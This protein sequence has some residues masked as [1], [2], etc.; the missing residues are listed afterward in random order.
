[1]RHV[2]RSRFC[3]N[4][5]LSV[6]L[7]LRI[8][9]AEE[10][11]VVPVSQVLLEEEYQIA[12]VEGLEPLVP[13]D[14]LEPVTSITGEVKPQ[15]AYVALVL[16]PWHRGWGCLPLLCPTPDDVVIVRGECLAEV[17]FMLVWRVDPLRV[18]EQP[19]LIVRLWRRL[20]VSFGFVCSAPNESR[21]HI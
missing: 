10:V 9:Q 11:A 8:D 5:A 12:G 7:L 2:W 17:V 18:L 16:R 4:V 20:H 15:H 1:M 14:V 21:T 19:L 6:A 3:Y 13:A